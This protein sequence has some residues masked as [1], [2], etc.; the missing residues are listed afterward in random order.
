ME[1]QKFALRLL[2]LVFLVALLGFAA[3]AALTFLHSVDPS[4]G[5]AITL[6]QLHVTPNMMRSAASSYSRA[7]NNL[8]ALLLT[9]ISLAIPLTAN[10]YTPK[11]IEIFIRD[12]INLVVLCTYAILAG[13]S[14][15]A[16]SLS[17]DN[18][19]P[20]L[21]FWIDSVGAVLGWL[22]LMPYYFYVLSFIDPLTIIKRVHLSLMHELDDAA[23]GKYPIAQAQQ[24]V[25]QRIINL[26]SM[27]QRSV[28]RADR[29]VAFDAI[30]AHTLDLARVRG[31]KPRLPEAFFLV[32][33]AMMVGM[34]RPA[35]AMLSHERI[36]MEHRIASQLVLAFK[37]ALNKM[38]EGV[39]P[40]AHALKN[41]AHEE[42]KL[43]NEAVFRLLVRAL[44]SFL[45]EAI[46]KKENAQ[47]YAVIYNYKSLIRR[48]I[49][50]RPDAVVELTRHQRYYAEFARLQGLP[51]SYEL[52]SYELAELAEIA[53]ESG[54][55]AAAALLAA[56]LEFEGVDGSAGLVKSRAILAAYLLECGRTE[57]LA[58]I[59]SSL[60]GVPHALL[61]KARRGLLETTD[62]VFWEVTDRG[63]DM[64]YL[65]PERRERVATVFDRLVAATALDQPAP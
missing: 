24:R 15:L 23:S 3:E 36:W 20:Q 55:P 57:E 10:L 39:S 60:R 62:P 16:V 26:G 14:L 30:R 52:I 54:S 50:D 22:L 61:Y 19:T 13:H 4:T 34:S 47:V 21:P 53:Y 12:R 49:D 58:R 38:P 18:W 45:R 56:V 64:D 6:S 1:H 9:F 46:K 5:K 25:N 42:A 43:G 28:D 35:T 51:F 37:T 44:N 7:Y 41:A 27:L 65:A 8:L 63:I 40:L 32:D 59:E 29:D 2:K 11:L 17:F 33:N 31:I 48:L